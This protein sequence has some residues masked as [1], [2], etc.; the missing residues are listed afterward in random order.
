MA[1]DGT[2]HSHHIIPRAV[3][4]KV[5]GALVFLTILTV[6]TAQYMDF[7][8]F[9]VPLAL[10][11]AGVKAALVVMFFMALWY[12]KGVN[13]MVFSIGA[14]F[15]AVFLLF[16]I[17]D[18]AFRGDIGNVDP[19]TIAEQERREEQ[20]REQEPSPEELRV[21]PADFGEEEDTTAVQEEGAPADTTAQP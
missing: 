18:T 8:M 6:V 12:D 3:L 4:L 17:L 13:A 16:T 14:V 11:I 21:A 9:D 20:L 7:G 1:H 2:D 15:V 10:A 5:F 19:E